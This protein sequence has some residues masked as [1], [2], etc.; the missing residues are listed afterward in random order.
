[1]QARERAGSVTKT[2]QTVD[3]LPLAMLTHRSAGNDSGGN[4]QDRVKRGGDAG[5]IFR[6]REPVIAVLDQRERGI[7]RKI[8]DELQ[9]VLPGNI[10]I[11]HA[12]N[13]VDGAVECDRRTE[14]PT[15]AAILDQRARDGIRAV[16]IDGRTLPF[17]AFHDLA[18]DLWRH[19]FPNERF[20][21]I[22]GGGEQ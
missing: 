21:E 7:A 4:G 6:R 17:A 15:A 1:M 11:L 8:L 12:L 2:E 5:K 13:D 10:G 20:G 22:R 16:T 3:S 14:Q 19:A 18:A 9:R